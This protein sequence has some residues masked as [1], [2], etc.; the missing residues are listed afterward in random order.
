MSQAQRKPNF[1][2]SEILVE[3]SSNV[4]T[5]P[6]GFSSPDHNI[7]LKPIVPNFQAKIHHPAT[8]NPAPGNYGRGNT[9]FE[10]PLNGKRIAGKKT[11]PQSL[12]LTSEMLS[13]KQEKRR[14]SHKGNL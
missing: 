12:L 6:S 10:S 4:T 11:T 13:V 8:Y 5:P 7:N 2:A 3:P 9:S 14:T 1:L